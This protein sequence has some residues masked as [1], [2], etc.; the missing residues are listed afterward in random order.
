LLRTLSEVTAPGA[1]LVGDSVNF[2]GTGD[3]RL[4]IRYADAVTPWWSQRNVKALEIPA[5]VEGTGWRNERQIE[6]G[7][8]HAVVLRRTGA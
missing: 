5:L 4:R 3:V 2:R 1:V 8:D 6:D 7:D